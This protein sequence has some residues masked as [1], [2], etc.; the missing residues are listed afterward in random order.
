MPLLKLEACQSK[1][2]ILLYVVVVV[3]RR[4]LFVNC[5]VLLQPGTIFVFEF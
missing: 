5:K 2:G 3:R 4:C 1:F